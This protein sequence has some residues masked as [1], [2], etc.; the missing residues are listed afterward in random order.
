MNSMYRYCMRYSLFVVL[1]TLI[2]T[3]SV[4]AQNGPSKGRITGK[5]T[6]STTKAPV[7]FAT[8]SVYKIGAT[9]PVNGISTDQK[10]FFAIDNLPAGEYRV[11]VDFIGYQAKTI[12]PVRIGP[13]ALIVS[14]KNILLAPAAKQLE[15]VTISAQAPAIQNKLDKM[16]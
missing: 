1:S 10:G 6:D 12:S 3:V 14:L 9:A 16:V 2:C 11:T 8:V 7:D 5:V 15:S 4:R 13:D